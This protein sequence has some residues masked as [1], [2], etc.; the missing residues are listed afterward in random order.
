MRMLLLL[1]LVTGFFLAEEAK[2]QSCGAGPAMCWPLQ[3]VT[4][5]TALSD[6]DYKVI[7]KPASS[8]TLVLDMPFCTSD[9]HSREFIIIDKGPGTVRIDAAS[10]DTIE[11]SATLTMA[12]YTLRV[13]LTCVWDAGTSTGR[14]YTTE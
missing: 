10:P 7:A 3:V 9:I 14:W 8:T 11:G 1:S 4:S 13:E 6:W 2:A 12:W 5:S